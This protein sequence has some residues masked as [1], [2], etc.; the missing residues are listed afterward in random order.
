MAK[1][2]KPRDPGKWDA[3][4]EGQRKRYLRNGITKAQ[5]V[6]GE[7]LSAARGHSATP[8]HRLEP[9]KATPQQKQKYSRYLA[10]QSDETYV[11]SSEGIKGPYPIK[12][13]TLKQESIIRAHWYRIRRYLGGS[14]TSASGPY[15]FQDITNELSVKSFE[16]I[17]V[18]GRNGIPKMKLEYRVDE[19]D[20]AAQAGIL[21]DKPVTLGS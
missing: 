5:Y 17:T 10:R 13:F 9:T 2:L 18:G 16:G 14:E 1:P 19:I 6:R 8:E 11:F 12:D 20:R 21:P 4:S 15:E 3:L 7:P